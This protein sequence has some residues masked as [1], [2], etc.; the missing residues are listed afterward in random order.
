[1]TQKDEQKTNH[2]SNFNY[3]IFKNVYFNAEF[4]QNF[5]FKNENKMYFRSKSYIKTYHICDYYVIYI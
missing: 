1:M 3:N 4:K 5:A 2:Y